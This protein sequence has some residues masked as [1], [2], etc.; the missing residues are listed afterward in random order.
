[1]GCSGQNPTSQTPEPVTV[2]VAA[3]TK[4]AVT[5]I[6]ALFKNDTGIEVKISADDSS[7]LAMQ[8]VNE[9]PAHLFLSA[10]E[11]WAEFVSDKGFAQETKLLL[12]NS[13]VLVTP[14]GNP[15]NVHSAQDLTKAI[16]KRVAIAGPTVPAGIYAR[17][18][19]RE[20]GV[21][22]SIEAEKKII[23]GENVRVTLAY[24]EQG[25]TD[26]GI[27]Y[28][29]D[30]KISNKIELVYTFPEMSHQ[31]IHYPLVL[32]IAGNQSASARSFFE[33]VQSARAKEIFVREGFSF[34][35]KK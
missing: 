21:W 28:A 34:L 32:L 26:A 35:D 18:A 23:S 30:A 14:K 9:A 5:E 3:S 13:L 16:V 31:P 4:E 33:F 1:M 22:D 17:Q 7:K 27:V 20:L 10:N 25:E 6:A 8:I 11:K 2:F 15:A 12:G 29:T 24:V 19:L